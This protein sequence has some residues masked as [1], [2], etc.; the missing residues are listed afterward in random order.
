M[1]VFVNDPCGI[2]CITFTYAALLY[3]DY[4]IIKWVV[5]QTMID[6]LWAP[7]H[8]VL[9]NTLIFLLSFAHLKA[10]CSDPGVVPLPQTKI[11]FSDMHSG[12]EG[13][14]Q[15]ENWTVCTRCETYRPP[16]AHHCRICKRCIRH[17]DHHCPWINNCVGE[18]NQQYFVQFLMYVGVLSLYA[19]VLVA[20]SWIKECTY[21]SEEI[22]IKQTRIL[23]CVILVMESTLFGIFVTAILYDQLEA[24]AKN[25]TT[26]EQLQSGSS[27]S[28]SMRRMCFSQLCRFPFEYSPLSNSSS[29]SS[30][31]SLR[32]STNKSLSSDIV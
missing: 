3:A 22:S 17:M 11:D 18:R 12:T 30:L 16:R 27:S 10:T 29:S 8:V 14:L 23:H 24:I 15:K 13:L 25:Q 5:M 4:V 21:C 7:V 6:S 20:F 19:I 26:I 9:F 1:T 28:Y 31:H 32:N 2:I